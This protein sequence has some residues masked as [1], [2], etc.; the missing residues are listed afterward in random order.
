[1]SVLSGC[2]KLYSLKSIYPT[3][4]GTVLI[5]VLDQFKGSGQTLLLANAAKNKKREISI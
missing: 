1:M 5:V 4:Q 2:K 3:I